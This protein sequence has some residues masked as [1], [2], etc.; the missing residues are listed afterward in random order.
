MMNVRLPDTVAELE[1]AFATNSYIPGR[2]FGPLHATDERPGIHIH[3]SFSTNRDVCDSVATLAMAGAA[4]AFERVGLDARIYLLGG[5]VVLH[6]LSWTMVSSFCKGANQLST[7]NNPDGPRFTFVEVPHEEY[8]GLALT[9]HLSGHQSPSGELQQLLST[10]L[11]EDHHEVGAHGA[12]RP[13]INNSP[14]LV[15]AV[16]EIAREKYDKYME[17]LHVHGANSTEYKLAFEA[18]CEFTRRYDA[19]STS[20]T[21]AYLVRLGSPEAQ[22]T[23]Y[24]RF[25]NLFGRKA[26]ELMDAGVR[27]VKSF[28][29]LAPA[30]Q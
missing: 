3:E 22:R 8:S 23:A 18:L 9:A 15:S 29:E 14:E 19:F 4:S 17:A 6:A 12:T 24:R 30:S 20:Q 13:I 16:A 1:A 27:S 5:N 25:A 7:P 11:L 2:N 10:Y 26:E 21:F 28:T